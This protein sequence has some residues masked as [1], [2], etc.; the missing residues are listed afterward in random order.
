MQS[1]FCWH[2]PQHGLCP[3]LQESCRIPQLLPDS[4]TRDK[5]CQQH[6]QKVVFSLFILASV[7]VHI[8]LANTGAPLTQPPEVFSGFDSHPSHA[9]P[10]STLEWKWSTCSSSLN[11]WFN[12][13]WVNQQQCLSLHWSKESSEKSK[14][15]AGIGWWGECRR[16]V[17]LADGNTTNIALMPRCCPG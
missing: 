17:S 8:L 7:G 16:T 10:G 15:C 3:K 9:I 4:Q 6:F 13:R 2:S 11:L 12:W 1:F 5:V 14:E